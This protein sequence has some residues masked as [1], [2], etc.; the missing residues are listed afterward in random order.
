MVIPTK[1]DCQF[2]LLSVEEWPDLCYLKEES[3]HHVCEMQECVASLL[4]KI[5]TR[6]FAKIL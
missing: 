2:L 3:A 6:A 5:V 4:I 1:R